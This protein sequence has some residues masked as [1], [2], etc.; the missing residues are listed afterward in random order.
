[1]INTNR[2][3]SD[4]AG[5][6]KHLIFL[7][8]YGNAHEVIE[9]MTNGHDL[10]EVEAEIRRHHL[11]AGKR[12]SVLDF[13]EDEVKRCEDLGIRIVSFL[14]G[15][16]PPALRV[17]YDPPLALY[18]KGNLI[19]SDDQAVAVVGTRHPTLY[20]RMQAGKF[21]RNLAEK[22]LTIVSG[23]AQGIDQAS[24][25]A[26]LKISFGRTLAVLGCG[27]DI[28]YPKH[29]GKLRA[30]ICER[31][32]VLTEFCLGTQPHAA[33]F[34]KRNRIIAGLSL[35]VIVIEAH[36]RSGSL[37]TAH[38][39]VEQ[40][41]DVFAVPG[42][43]DLPGSRGAHRL[44]K[45]GAYLAESHEDILETLYYRLKD[46]SENRERKSPLPVPLMRTKSVSPTNEL[47]EFPECQNPVLSLDSAILALIQDHDQT[48]EDLMI[49]TGQTASGLNQALTRLE[50]SG[51]IKKNYAGVYRVLRP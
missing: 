49:E 22:G 1:M 46:Q 27:L 32:A 7:N 34:P 40:G 44:I 41:K 36:V 45:E 11:N 12:E 26:A 48:A 19:A 4:A 39:A 31:G 21:S 8:R 20:G 18:M 2:S 25:E 50:C 42:P 28:D 43:V 16:Y 24:H 23:L 38:Q 3:H 15:D 17:L 51:K 33:H 47:E 9:A 5:N 14:D 29:S 30:Q 6:L 10:A 37:I 13:A 35:A